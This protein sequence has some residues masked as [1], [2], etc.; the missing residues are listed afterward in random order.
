MD[1]E[2][3]FKTMTESSKVASSAAKSLA[4]SQSA[5]TA[6]N[7]GAITGAG[8]EA[9]LDIAKFL[10][11]MGLPDKGNVIANTETFRGAMQPV[12]ASIMHQT[13][14]TSQ[15]SEGE[16]KFAAK[17]AAGDITLDAQSIRQLT[18]IIDKAS[19]GIIES[20]QKK[21]DVLF[22]DNPQAKALFGVEMP[23]PP[24]TAGSVVDVPARQRRRN[25][26]RA[27]RSASTDGQARCS[28]GY[29]L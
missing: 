17:A 3:V 1:P 27:P 21:M 20:H 19:R 5:I 12:V 18:T 11:N 10:H 6:L 24:A 16:L 25:C 2:T 4:A 22:P 23:K 9:R 28:N 7:A 8:A 14:G 29:C 15:L 13:S 26:R